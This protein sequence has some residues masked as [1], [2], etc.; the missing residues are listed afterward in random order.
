MHVLIRYQEGEGVNK[1]GNINVAKDDFEA[2]IC[3]NTYHIAHIDYINNWFLDIVLE[4]KISHQRI[5]ITNIEEN[6]TVFQL[7][8]TIC[9]TLMCIEYLDSN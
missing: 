2:N 5:H 8:Y 3:N 7:L 1:N 4:S 6:T 9:V